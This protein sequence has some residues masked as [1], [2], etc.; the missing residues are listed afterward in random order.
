MELAGH[1]NRLFAVR[2]LADHVESV[3]LEQRRECLP[4]QG[5][6]IDD[7]NAL[8]GHMALIGKSPPAD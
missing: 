6:I 3:L 4:R 5:V 2:G 8:F 1:C 7:E